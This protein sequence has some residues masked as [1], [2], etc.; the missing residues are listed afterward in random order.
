[1][2]GYSSVAGL[3]YWG[4]WRG[5]GT[6]AWLFFTIHTERGAEQPP[7][8]RGYSCLAPQGEFRVVERKI[9]MKEFLRALKDG[10]VREVFGS[11]TAC[12]VCPVHQILYQGKVR[13][14]Q[15][16]A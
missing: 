5:L 4:W 15:L 13:K 11:G 8:L 16:R 12:Q 14:G 10:R 7:G 9:T 3:E 1:M 6:M 2:M